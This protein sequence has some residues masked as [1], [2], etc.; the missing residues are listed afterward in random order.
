MGQDMRLILVCGPAGSG[1]DTIG[2]FLADK[3][4]FLHLSAGDVLR[5]AAIAQGHAEPI[6]REV[7]TQVGN[8]LHQQYGAGPIVAYALEEY[9]RRQAEYP[10]GLVLSGLRRMHEIGRAKQEGAAV[11]YIDAPDRLSFERVTDRSRGDDASYQGFIARRKT[12][13]DGTTD[14]GKEGIWLEG[15]ADVADMLLVNDDSL[16]TL[17]AAV[18]KKLGL[19]A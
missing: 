9:G 11:M 17:F 19:A 3:Y 12:E 2:N 1:K 5:A 6:S 10:G 7:L 4:G 8:A 15:I 18:T 16:E 14:E 13:F